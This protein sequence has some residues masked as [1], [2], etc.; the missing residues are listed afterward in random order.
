MFQV[1]LAVNTDR[2]V[3]T[4]NGR[5]PSV[6]VPAD[7]D[8]YVRHGLP[9]TTTQFDCATVGPSQL[10]DCRFDNPTAGTWY[11]LL[12]LVTGEGQFQFNA[13]ALGG[14]PPVCGNAVREP[15]EDCDLGDDDNCPGTCDSSCVCP[16]VCS[17]GPVEIRRLVTS[18][19]R[20][21]FKARLID[22][23]SGPPLSGLDPR[24]SFS[25]LLTDGTVSLDLSVPDFDHGWQ[26]SKPEKGRYKWKGNVDGIRRIKVFDR[27]AA[28]GFTKVVVRA[29]GVPVAAALAV[30]TT[31]TE[32]D[33]DGTCVTQ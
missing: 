20:I 4:F 27:V 11:A 28:R 7:F 8:L 14:D 30:G 10:G 24:V 3:F 9:P 18:T 15:G 22:D 33:I 31:T 29:V 12:R 1:P 5:N 23:G 19:K 2:V 6:G 21:A 26:R 13:T 25:T 32:V 17:P 16:K